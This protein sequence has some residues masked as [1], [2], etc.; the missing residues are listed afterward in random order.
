MSVHWKSCCRG[1][2][3]V[4]TRYLAKW[5]VLS[6][7]IGLVAGVGAIAFY[8]AIAHVYREKAGQPLA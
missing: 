4:S 2:G 7:C 8:L 6:T 5:L 3:F 1:S